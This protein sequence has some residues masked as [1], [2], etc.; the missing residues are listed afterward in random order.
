[1]LKN[2]L[3]RGL[4]PTI[5]TILYIYSLFKKK[6]TEE[7]EKKTR[8][9]ESYESHS[10]FDSLGFL[11]LDFHLGGPFQRTFRCG[12]EKVLRGLSHCTSHLFKNIAPNFILRHS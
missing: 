11:M 5:F 2:C 9:L 12:F 4:Q 1:M 8:V 10:H 3:A 6:E 7:K